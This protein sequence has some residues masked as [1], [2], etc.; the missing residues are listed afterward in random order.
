MCRYFQL[1]NPTYIPFYFSTMLITLNTA[2]TYIRL[3]KIDRQDI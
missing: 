1:E 3:Y 2:V